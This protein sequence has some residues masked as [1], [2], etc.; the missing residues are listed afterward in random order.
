MA[1]SGEGKVSLALLNYDKSFGKG[2]IRVKTDL[3]GSTSLIETLSIEQPYTLVA[4]DGR[5]NLSVSE[6]AEFIGLG[7]FNISQ[8]F[9]KEI[10]GASPITTRV[11]LPNI[12]N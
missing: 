2:T 6:T 11:A 5:G 1:W 7:L 10:V 4:K 12:L 8:S 3:S 9:S